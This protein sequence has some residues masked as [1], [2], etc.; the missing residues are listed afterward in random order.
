MNSDIAGIERKIECAVAEWNMLPDGCP[1]VVGLSGGADSVALTHF[2]LR[3]AAGHGIFLT[4]AHVNHC[5][6]GEESDS[7]ERFVREF[8][9]RNRLELHVN[10]VD[11]RAAAERQSMGIE[12]CGRAVRYSFFKRL[13]GENGR[14]ATAHTLSDSAETVLMNLAKGTGP[15]GLCGI[16]PVRDNIVRPLIGVTRSEV[17]QYC[18]CYHLP[19][20]TDS[21]NLEEKYAR[22]R[23]RLQ[24]VPALK[25]VNPSF[26]ECLLRTERLLRCDEEY[27]EALAQKSE[28]GA[29][30]PSGGYRLDVLQRLPEAVLLRV[31]QTALHRISRARFGYEHIAAVESI[32][33]SGNGAVTAAGGIQCYVT[34]N[35]LFVAE[36]YPEK[37]PQWS[38]PLNCSSVL[39]P[40][41]REFRLRRPAEGEWKNRGSEKI[42]KLLFN[43]FIN[44]DTITNNGS[45]VRNRREG[46]TFRPPFRGVS[47]SLKK[48]FNEARIPTAQRG[49]L[50]VLECG[51]RILW[52][53]GFGV[54]EEARV[55]SDTREAAEIIIK[56]RNDSAYDER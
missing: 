17:E 49:R 13:C 52:V 7:D 55:S 43:N 48:L 37:V 1:V 29:R 27:L 54:S 35:T 25:T 33:R 34:G 39:L 10:R 4:A 45:F 22:N 30:D 53:E 16:P 12:E 21:T 20:V 31:I 6:R 36:K 19:F 9:E 5:L 50:A 8:C 3:Y 46:D 40:D 18:A 24:A 56:E 23:I 15:R 26:E 28:V 47:K 11:V 14:I 42:N 38:V 2:L 44:Y 32:V 41:G 51:G